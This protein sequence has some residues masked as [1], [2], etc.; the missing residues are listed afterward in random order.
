MSAGL[1]P[2]SSARLQDEVGQW[3][4]WYFDIRVGTFDDHRGSIEKGR[5]RKTIC[6][7]SWDE[8]LVIYQLTFSFAI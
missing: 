2:S 8:L 5:L 3:D 4:L 1:S 6:H 7:W